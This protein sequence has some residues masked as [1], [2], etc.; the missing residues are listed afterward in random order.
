MDVALINAIENDADAT[1]ESCHPYSVG[2]PFA[3]DSINRE[4]CRTGESDVDL[5]VELAQ[6]LGH[7]KLDAIVLGLNRPQTFLP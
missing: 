2:K 6:I 7:A 5:L 1:A 4:D 3:S